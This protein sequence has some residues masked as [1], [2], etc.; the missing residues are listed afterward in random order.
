MNGPT[1]THET[2]SVTSPP[3]DV[4]SE[5]PVATR[6]QTLPFGSLTW[7]NFERLCHRLA[8]LADNVEHCARY[9]RQG[10]EQAGIDI[11]ARQ[12]NGKYHCLQA[13]RH[14]NFN[15][16]KIEKAVDLFLEGKWATKAEQ[17]T[18]AVQCSL[19][20]TTAQD[21]IERQAKRLLEKGVAFHAIDGEDLTNKL[22]QHPEIVDDFFGRP[23]VAAVLGDEVAKQLKN[24]PDGAAFAKARA[25]LTRVYETNF[26]FV[27]P[28]SFGSIGDDQ[29]LVALTLLERFQ[30]PDILLRETTS[31]IE[32][33][34]E[35][36]ER[37]KDDEDKAIPKSENSERS[38][39][40]S[41]LNTGNRIRRLPMSEWVSETE[42]LVVLGDAG[43]GKSTLLRVI[44]LDLLRTQTH[45]PELSA[46]WGYHLP[47]YISFAR[48]STQVGRTGGIVSIKDIVRHSLEQLMTTP[49][50][51]LIDQVIDDG[52]ALLLI[53]GLDEWS[54][55][56]AA[57]TTLGALVTFVETHNI[58]VVVSGR[59]KG[60]EKIGTI[61]A[62][63]R[64]GTVA[65]LSPTQQICIASRWFSRFSTDQ[66]ILAETSEVSLR[67]D[68][69]RAELARDANLAALAT[70]PLLLIGLI[71]LAL[72]GQ[73]LPRTQ[74]EVYNQLVRL[75]LE[76]HPNS[77]ATAAG[78]TDS[79]FH[80][81]AD[82][83]QRR[84]V[85]AYLAFTIRAQVGGGNVSRV[86][87]REKLQEFLASP[88]N[89]A[90]DS[91]TA[92][93][94][95][96][97]ILSVNS[98]TQGLIIE[99]A[100]A[101]VGFVHA[102]FE[103]YLSAEHIGSWPFE[104][105]TSFLQAHA[106]EE[107]W[108]NV[109]TNLLSQLQRR[110]EIDR[111]V[112]IIKEPRK[113]E[114]S[115]LSCK[116]LLG[117]IAFA[118]STRARTTAQ[119][120]ALSTMERV[121]SEDWT[122]GRREAL[123]SVLKG[124]SDPTLQTEVAHRLAQWLPDS[125]QWRPSLID[126]LGSWQ[127]SSELQETLFRAMH[128]EDNYVQRSA[129]KTYAKLFS[130]SDAAYQ[131]LVN[132][133]SKS[134][135][136][137]ASAALLES[138]AHGWFKAPNTE[139]LFQQAW[140]HHRGELRLVG[141]LGLL[142]R[143]SRLA[144]IRDFVLQAQSFW[145]LRSITHR[146]L[147]V[148]MLITYWPNDPEF[149]QGAIERLSH[150]GS[151]V[152]EHDSA[153]QY[154]F[155]C[156]IN[157]HKIHQWVLKAF[158]E[159]YPF[160]FHLGNQRE[161]DFIGRLSAH[162]TD[163]RSAATK[164]WQDPKN[165][166]IGIHK[167]ASYVTHVAD[168]EI[169]AVLKE[170]LADKK[171]NFN[172]LWALDALL[173]GWGRNH[174]DAKPMLD[175]II[176]GPDEEI[177][178]L[179]SLL[180]KVYEDKVDARN[181]LLS[182]GRRSTVRRDLITQGFALCGCDGSDDEVVKVITSNMQERGSAYDLSHQ[183]FNSF[184]THP[185]VREMA[186]QSLHI[187]NGP[188]SAIAT[189]Y[190]NDSEF[191]PTILAAATPL[192]TGLRTQIVEFAAEGATGTALE[193]VLEKALLESDPELRVRMA[194]AHYRKLPANE[195][196]TAKQELLKQAIAVGPDFDA[197][198]AAA[199][200]GLTALGAL[201][202][203]VEIKDGDKPLKLSTGRGMDP[204]PSLERLICQNFSDFELAF[205]EKLQARFESWSRQDRL[206]E[207]LTAAPS[208]SPAARSAFL[209]MA[210]R[211]ELPKTLQ[212]I[213][214]LAGERPRS[215]LLLKTCWDVLEHK[216]R[217]NTSVSINAEIAIILRSHFPGNFEVREK[218]IN[219]FKQSPTTDTAITLAI[220]SPDARELPNPSIRE[221]G[222]GLGNWTI[223]IHIA[224]R[225]ANS[226]EFV[227]LMEDMVTRDFRSQFDVQTITNLAVQERLLTDAELVELLS[228]RLHENVDCSISGSFARYLA[229]ASKFDEGVRTKVVNLLNTITKDQ[230]LALAGYDAIADDWRCTR[231]TLLDALSAG[232]DLD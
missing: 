172:R 220:Y 16:S 138:L 120:L 183:L 224:A 188:L 212:A 61:P 83:D 20:S 195:H 140:S 217:N 46:R 52:R 107:R 96:D 48:W 26:H 9:G 166:V 211:G 65:P 149:I 206:A 180:P 59:P 42:R 102:S 91:T 97:E 77:R 216:E 186:K 147:A 144:E 70:T 193:K 73:I 151:S 139:N 72:R 148:E 208:A 146:S 88:A 15:A 49:L 89:L 41:L 156:S 155:S 57:R 226:A 190:A 79:R 90:L 153:A 196:A 103:E 128:D 121:E 201:G 93:K 98:E 167:L 101:E 177:E 32:V 8:S 22:R 132:G 78:D 37:A 182:I 152:W 197:V 81:V 154:L 185:I 194:I 215:K 130:T 173:T 69:F 6:I 106:G 43:S 129:A 105:I 115:Q 170:I 230:G 25:Q 3:D 23:W 35:H 205:G 228:A 150:H 135:D 125:Q 218:L 10:D 60:L 231:A 87:A 222:Q 131:R 71:T 171:S 29:G 12:F 164:Y 2:L 142:N 158:N 123:N 176:S 159:D 30:K 199:L 168:P 179:T 203:L 40:H 210:E 50:A 94:A 82:P 44:A 134:R 112:A 74:S 219:L 64:R 133:L 75:L 7:E 13:K 1:S 19:R 118:I 95:A 51:D 162:H 62:T 100:P 24:R 99:K 108:R 200:A 18:I 189:G 198:R 161:W 143:G 110:D 232:L 104:Q 141:A 66:R 191:A 160:N 5:L 169:L 58:P 157:N 34:K 214:A 124:V 213:R 38:Q 17:F 165:R 122:P 184:G 67:T 31:S 54:N 27:D 227:A 45:F 14:Q 178:D 225:R 53:D 209:E 221:I 175:A 192:P 76:V 28:G 174:V 113:D 136:L 55:E 145:A 114:I 68:R 117:D 126:A 204:M 119:E 202:D 80:H 21:E 63:W 86:F 11:Y 85:I 229:S 109:I 137:H 36:V 33:S 116:A 181:R 4:A 47:L 223:A 207:I 163:I 111:L 187:P 84:A 92:R 56:Q 39:T 127:P